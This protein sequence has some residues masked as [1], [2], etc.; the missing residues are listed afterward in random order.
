MPAPA[1]EGL[2]FQE[3]Q[4]AAKRT[5]F[6]KKVRG[7][8]RGKR[9]TA[10]SGKKMSKWSAL[11]T[12]VAT[13]NQQLRAKLLEQ[14]QKV[15]FEGLSGTISFDARGDRLAPYKILN[16]QDVNGAATFVN[17]GTFDGATDKVTFTTDPI[18]ADGSTTAQC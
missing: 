9:S 14:L 3:S 6:A 16:I 7:N 1:I 10:I 5:G 4:F 8:G 17:I 18:Y 13:Q 12:S 11:K 15:S 2:L